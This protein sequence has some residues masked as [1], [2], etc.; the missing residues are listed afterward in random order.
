M[1]LKEQTV[2]IP[3]ENFTDYFMSNDEND[4][5]DGFLEKIENQILLS[6]GELVE[7]V[8]KVIDDYSDSLLSAIS[9][10][11]LDTINQSKAD[12]D[13]D[14]QVFQAVVET[15]TTF[16]RPSKEQFINN[17]FNKQ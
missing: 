7:L 13:S 1:N 10:C 15:I 2:Y 8:G 12:K 5:K 14:K 4:E 17:L 11:F 3:T 9:N 16:P 6:K